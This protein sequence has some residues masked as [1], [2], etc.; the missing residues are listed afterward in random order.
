MELLIND[1]PIGITPQESDTVQTLLKAV[2][3]ELEEDLIIASMIID[4]EYCSID[5]PEVLGTPVSKIQKIEL[6]VATRIE[7]GLSILED[8]KQ[9]ILIGA[10]EFKNGSWSKKEE[11]LHSF[12]WILD[13][14][15]ALQSSL[16]FPPTDLP[17]VK[18]LIIQIIRK[19]DHSP[20]TLEEAQALGTELERIAPLFDVLK[21]KIANEQTF[22]RES[23]FQKL[24]EIQPLLPEIATNFQ[25]GNDFKAIQELCRI[26]DTIEM[27]TRFTSLHTDNSLLTQHSLALRDLSLQ[28]LQAFENKDFILIADLIE[29]D[30]NEHIDTIL[31][32]E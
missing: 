6:L 28:L 15:E 27:F 30:L 17:I 22:S 1:T 7:I 25:T 24:K 12:T 14:I 2:V 20:L 26:V 18:S 3:K 11:L 5:D 32:T 10:Q 29:Y 8:G 19:I 4:N 16:P 21:E 23:T 9:F 13:S 31:E